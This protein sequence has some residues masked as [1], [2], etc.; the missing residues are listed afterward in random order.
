LDFD[1]AVVRLDTDGAAAA[2]KSDDRPNTLKNY[3]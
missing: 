2:Q 3:K 1:N